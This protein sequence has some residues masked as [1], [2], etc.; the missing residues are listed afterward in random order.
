MT[1]STFT[2]ELVWRARAGGG[3]KTQRDYLDFV[4]NGQS[5]SELLQVGDFIGSLGWGSPTFDE[6]I[7]GEL[8]LKQL[9]DLRENRCRLYI[10]PECGD[11]GCGA[12]TVQVYKSA[13]HFTWANFSFDDNFTVYKVYEGIGPFHFGRQQYWQTLTSRPTLLKN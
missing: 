8:L 9:S 12:I 13:D 3:G 10:C 1:D 5:L 7:L 2:L 11:I 6:Q 4:I